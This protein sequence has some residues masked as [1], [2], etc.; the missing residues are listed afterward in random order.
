MCLYQL[1][2][3][4]SNRV[5]T[6][7]CL[8]KPQHYFTLAVG[9][10]HSYMCLVES[11]WKRLQCNVHTWLLKLLEDGVSA[12]TFEGR[13]EPLPT[14]LDNDVFEG[15]LFKLWRKSKFSWLTGNDV[16][17]PRRRKMQRCNTA[18]QEST[19]TWSEKPL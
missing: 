18:L 2:L 16:W 13:A 8:L 7:Q 1:T 5:A 9:C 4:F 17:T 12:A 14:S 3:W 11:M 15:V 19:N 6:A 10:F